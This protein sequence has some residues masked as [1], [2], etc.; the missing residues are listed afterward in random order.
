MP[1]E[2]GHH[3]GTINQPPGLAMGSAR[4]PPVERSFVFEAEHLDG[5][6]RVAKLASHFPAT[7][8]DGPIGFR[9]CETHWRRLLNRSSMISGMACPR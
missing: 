7:R 3:H 8:P 1:S 2:F 5:S 4:T 9:A 6:H